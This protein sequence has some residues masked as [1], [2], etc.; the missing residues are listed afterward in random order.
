MGFDGPCAT[1]MGQKARATGI[2]GRTYDA[3]PSLAFRRAFEHVRTI[4]ATRTLC[5][6][7]PHAPLARLFGVQGLLPEPADGPRP[8]LALSQSVRM[9][10][11]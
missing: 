6:D 7:H 2:W 10:G 4:Q 3:M 1:G 9:E 8:G 11:L 5:V